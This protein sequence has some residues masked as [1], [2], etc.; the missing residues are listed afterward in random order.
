MKNIDCL[1][2]RNNA[3]AITF[4]TKGQFLLVQLLGWPADFWKFPQGG[5]HEGES[6]EEAILRELSEELGI[7]DF[8]IIA[9][10]RHTN[11]YD[12]DN[13]SI[14]KAGFKWRGQFQKF[15]LVEISGICNEIKIDEKEIQNW[16][17]VDRE[18]IFESIDHDHKLFENYR[19]VIESVLDEFKD[20]LP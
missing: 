4:N 7:R 3:A 12:W 5:V 8:K 14:R 2:Y 11:R 15:F 6:E 10:S 20:L 1:P 17:W 16:R 9:K 19:N 13:D 18:H